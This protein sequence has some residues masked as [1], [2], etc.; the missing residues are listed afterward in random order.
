MSIAKVWRD[1]LTL[2]KLDATMEK[3]LT[4]STALLL[5]IS[6]VAGL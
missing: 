3:W 2:S 1:L 5:E 6:G 4:H